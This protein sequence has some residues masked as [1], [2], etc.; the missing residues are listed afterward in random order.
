MSYSLFR[1]TLLLVD[2]LNDESSLQMKYQ[3]IRILNIRSEVF[4]SFDL[5]KLHNIFNVKHSI[6]I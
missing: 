3:L 5:M 4:F 1:S 6:Q 2:E